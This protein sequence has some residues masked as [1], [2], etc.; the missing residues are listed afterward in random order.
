MPVQIGAKAHNFT[1]PTGLLSDCHRR[2]E[3]FLGTLEAVAQVIDRPAT[4]ETRRALEAALRYFA[5]AAPKHTADE[6]VSLFPRLRQIHD[7][8]IE[9]AFSKLDRLEEEHRRAT[10]L[11]AEVDRLGA[12]FLSNGSLSNPEVDSFRKAVASLASM[13]KQHIRVE[14][15]LVFP[16][17]DRMLSDAEKLAIAEEM[18]G[19]RKVRVV[20][21]IST[22]RK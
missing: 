19:R 8:E 2:V 18:A 7:P 6:E 14:D 9:A 1:N 21:E 12:Q 20:T 16:L 5:Q 10:P 11:H 4:D 15:S 17:A 3:M 13:Y 22:G